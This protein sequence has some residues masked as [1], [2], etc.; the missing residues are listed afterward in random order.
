MP[1]NEGGPESHPHLVAT[2]HPSLPPPEW[3]QTQPSGKLG[4]WPPHGDKATTHCGVGGD[5]M[6]SQ[7]SY[8]PTQQSSGA[9]AKVSSGK[10]RLLAPHGV[11]LKPLPSAA[12]VGSEKANKK[13]RIK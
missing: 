9:H 4:L 1:D 8:P 11:K 2:G 6:E 13:R 12:E 7:D 10:P 3:C 5:H